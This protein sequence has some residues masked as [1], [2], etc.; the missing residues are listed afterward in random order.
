MFVWQGYP[1]T[2]IARG[3]GTHLLLIKDHLTHIRLKLVSDKIQTNQKKM[4]LNINFQALLLFLFNSRY[5]L[6]KLQSPPF[7]DFNL[8]FYNQN[9]FGLALCSLV[10][11]LLSLS[12]WLC[13]IIQLVGFI[14]W[15]SDFDI[16]YIFFYSSSSCYVCTCTVSVY[17]QI[18]TWLFLFYER[19]SGQNDI[20][21]SSAVT[22]RI[23]SRVLCC[24]ITVIRP[25]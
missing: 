22:I 12:V 23:Y 13:K 7:P 11:R 16:G 18:F 3:F 19:P 4:W 1:G 15:L 20:F 5:I 9:A 24:S 25:Q 6:T 10:L 2:L 17:L 8:C 14:F 21:Q